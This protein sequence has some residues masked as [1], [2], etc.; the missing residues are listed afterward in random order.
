MGRA[1][2]R[3]RRREGFTLI[4]LLT[5][6]AI[7]SVLAA[8]AIPQFSRHRVKAFDTRIRQDLRG[9]ALAQES[10]WDLT[11]AYYAG[12][13][14]DGMPGVRLSQGTVCTVQRADATSYQIQT[15]HPATTRRCTWASDT[16][17]SLNCN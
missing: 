7:V 1:R 17:P 8:V 9:A 11:G 2:R 4:E 6:V 14:C 5:V 10:Y 12:P 15:T 13:S 16:S 3:Q